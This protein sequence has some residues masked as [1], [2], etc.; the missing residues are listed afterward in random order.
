MAAYHCLP[1]L[2]I[3]SPN[4]QFLPGLLIQS[5][6]SSKNLKESILK[7]RGGRLIEF[8]VVPYYPL[9]VTNKVAWT[10]LPQ[11]GYNMP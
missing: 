6:S 10:Q 4:N 8:D 7:R 1:G 9:T 11:H 3:Q 2:L 5:L